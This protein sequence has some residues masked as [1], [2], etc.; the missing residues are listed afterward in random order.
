MFGNPKGF[1]PSTITYWYQKAIK[2][3]GVKYIKLHNLRHSHATWLI[4]NG[5]NIVAVSKRL[6]HASITQT[7]ETYTHLLK[8]TDSEMMCK[9]ND[10]KKS[11]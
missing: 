9:I 4:C 8:E 11:V 1:S 7:L 2:D 6:G 3:S 5:V 10:Y